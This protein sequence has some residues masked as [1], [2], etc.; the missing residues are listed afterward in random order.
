M[1][2]GKRNPEITDDK[3]KE[4]NAKERHGR[5]FLKSP[6]QVSRCLKR[7]SVWGENHVDEINSRLDNAKNNELDIAKETIQIETERLRE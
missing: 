5:F 7:S 6:N 1:R 4:A 2:S 3:I